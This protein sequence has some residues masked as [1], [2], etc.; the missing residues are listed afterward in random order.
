MPRDPK[1]LVTLTSAKD[2]FEAEVIVQAL[3]AQG[4]EARAFSTAAS[5]LQWEVA[6]TDPV[7]VQVRREDVPLARAAL[8]EVKI[9][10][11][12]ID[13][14]TVDVHEE[15]GPEGDLGAAAPDAGSRADGAPRLILVLALIVA[16]IAVLTLLLSR[17]GLPDYAG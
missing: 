1:M 2:S 8:R 4:I 16:A 12:E 5:A 10:S 17:V 3:Q 15:D 9:E 13:W 14:D 6:M 11:V 7:K